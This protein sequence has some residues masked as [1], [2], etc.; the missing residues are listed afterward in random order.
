[1]IM[2]AEQNAK[3]LMTATPFVL[4]NKCLILGKLPCNIGNKIKY[5]FQVPYLA[6]TYFHFS[7]AFQRHTS[8][9]YLFIF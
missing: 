2:Q 9:M 5:N 3:Q 6:E 4:E 8:F 1:M 7:N